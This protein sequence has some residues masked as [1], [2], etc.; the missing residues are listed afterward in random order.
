MLD[1]YKPIHAVRYTTYSRL[2]SGFLQNRVRRAAFRTR[3]L[4][5]RTIL[6]CLV[7]AGNVHSAQAAPAP[8]YQ[9]SPPL[10]LAFVF[11]SNFPP[12]HLL[13]VIYRSETQEI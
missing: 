10:R 3:S 4:E 11:L 13:S 12:V 7:T 8:I 6:R 9:F 1:R 2:L 5:P